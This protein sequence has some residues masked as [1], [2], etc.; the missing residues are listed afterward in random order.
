MINDTLSKFKTSK[1]G[2]NESEVL[3]RQ[4]KYGLNELEEQ[5]AKGPLFLLLEQFIDVLIALL[6][7]AAIAA[8]AVGDVIDAGVIVL[9]IL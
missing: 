2:L 5:K 9:A 8:Y 3:K 6:I 7:I 1:D 4:E